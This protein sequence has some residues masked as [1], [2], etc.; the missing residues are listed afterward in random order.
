MVSGKQSKNINYLI[1]P[2]GTAADAAGK[3]INSPSFV[4]RQVLD[5]LLSIATEKDSIYLAPA[6]DFGCGR[7]EQELALDYLRLKSA[8]LHLIC[9]KTETDEY[10]DT[11][12]NALYMKRFLKNEI[13]NIVFELVCAL[14]HSYRAEFCFKK[15]G[16]RL[17]KIHRVKYAVT[18]ENVVGRLWYYKYK[19]IHV[20]YEL[21]SFARDK[22]KT[23]RDNG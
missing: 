22:I 1:V 18:G 4:Y 16:F 9:P 14:F 3:P 5:Y 20:I 12:G 15:A 6:N 11:Y 21:L 19:P 10:V 8:N 7:Y 23:R 17:S 13:D 2:D